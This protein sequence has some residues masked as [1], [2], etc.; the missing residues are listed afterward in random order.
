MAL[1]REV[2]ARVVLVERDREVR[3]G[4]V[5]AQA[6]VEA[7]LVALDEVVLGQQRLGLGGHEQEVDLV[8]AVD[9][10]DRAARDPVGEVAGDALADRLRLADVDDLAR[11]VVEQVDAGPV[12]QVAALL[13]R[14]GG[15]GGWRAWRPSLRA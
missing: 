5:V 10:L 1:A 3:V 14:A 7:R 4:L 12:G 2:D 13:A 8:D 11:V 15:G 6:D 9:H